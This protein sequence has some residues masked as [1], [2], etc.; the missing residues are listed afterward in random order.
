MAGFWV[1]RIGE[2]RVPSGLISG[3][4]DGA[5]AGKPAPTGIGVKL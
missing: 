3:D 5:I 1:E 4:L 2:G